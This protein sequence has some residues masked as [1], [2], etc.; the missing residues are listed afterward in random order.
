MKK[1]II[2]SSFL[3]T[4]FS[5][6]AQLNRGYWKS[7][8]EKEI[9]ITGKREIVPEKFKTYHLEIEALKND[10]LNAPN[11]KIVLIDNSNTIIELPMPN[12]EIQRFKVV[13]APIMDQDLQNSFPD[14]KT[15]SIKGID[16]TYANG[17]IDVTE[18]G[19]HGF[20][21][22]VNGDIFIDPYCQK[23]TSDYISYYTNDFIKPLNERGTCL[24]VIGETESNLNAEISAPS[25]IICSGANLKTYR[26]AIACTKEY[27]IAAT[28]SATPTKA[29]TLAKVNTTVNRVNFVYETEV[30]VR[31][32]LVSTS[33]LVLY[34]SATGSG[35]TT[36]DN[37]DAGALIS[38]SQSV[39]TASV[40]TA[41][42]DIGHTF[43]TGGGGLASLGC[44]CVSGSKASGITGS[45][46]PVGDPYDIDYVAHEIGHQ[47]RGNHTFN[48]STGSC[49]GNAN[50]STAVEPGSGVT[51]MAY[52]GICG[53]GQDL[54]ANSIAYFQAVSFDEIMAF[55]TSGS[56]AGCDVLTTTSN[57]SPVV[58]GS[59]SYVIPKGT[60]FQLTGSATDGNGDALTYSWEEVD[61]GTARGSWNMGT[62]P[63][64]RSNAPIASPTRLFPKLSTILAGTYTTT[65]GEFLPTT[66]AT[67][68]TIPLKF[69][70]TARDN[71]TGGGGVCSALST[72]TITG[73][74]G[75]FAV[76][77]Q[78]TTG[79]VYPTGS[80]Q[81]VNWNV[82]NTNIAPV[83]CF[84]VNIYISV[85]NG[86]N[87][88]LLLANTP[89]D[90]TEQVYMPVLPATKT[91][92]RI[93][94]E[95]VG[96]VFLDINKKMFS[97]SVVT[98][99]NQYANAA[100]IKMQLYPNPFSGTVKIDI[101]A[102]NFLDE[103]KTVINV[104]DIL[105][106]IVRSEN[107]KLTENFSKEFDFSSLS[108]GTYIV[109]VTDGTQKTVARLV[110]I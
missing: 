51:I 84:S 65:V 76:T 99:L 7:V 42:F 60:P 43:S 17:K 55:I 74:A 6:K 105:G 101:N 49:S 52:A 87:F 98:G 106:N 16:D 1:I 48:G 80:L 83:N 13:D 40:G 97:I 94:V 90:G 102:I 4:C 88:T 23:N 8:S 71:K 19:F 35:F 96:N 20:I 75:P 33:T 15:Y 44:V 93:K 5:S 25:A 73:A 57:S 3:I 69:R 32:V 31:L 50:S 9:A 11:D 18:F 77:S 53:S 29:Q 109:E 37:D 12:G 66:V 22:S 100:T 47:F 14:I 79:I 110:K 54:A 59:A 38:K 95:S 41:N 70:F 30:A 56:G 36:A 92:C 61:A 46:S 81:T 62:R 91:T 21:R 78:S 107:I 89:N 63:F 72:V 67:N 86:N 104:Y 108:N 34:T 26:L 64:F 45:P 68:T 58:T 85:D 82:N 103:N 2:L 27:A 24:G 39:I 10:L 28:G